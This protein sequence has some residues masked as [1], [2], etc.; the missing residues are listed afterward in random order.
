M[1]TTH[2]W[3]DLR[4]SAFFTVFGLSSTSHVFSK[5]QKEIFMSILKLAYYRN[6]AYHKGMAVKVAGRDAC[7]FEIYCVR[8]LTN[9]SPGYEMGER[10]M[11]VYL[12]GL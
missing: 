12:L 5:G 10:E 8:P 1:S 6:V 11:I 4:V 7:G 3:A 2:M 9:N